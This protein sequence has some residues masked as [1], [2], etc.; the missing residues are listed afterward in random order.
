MKGN[1]LL[2]KRLMWQ[3]VR[4]FLLLG[5]LLVG[6]SVPLYSQIYSPYYQY[7]PLFQYAIFYNIN[8]EVDPGAAMPIV[9]PVFSNEG[10]WSG[11]NNPIYAS[12]VEAAGQVNTNGADPFL[13]TYTVSGGTPA[14]NFLAP[15]QPVSGV[16]PVL[17]PGFGTNNLEAMLNLPPANVA[18]PQEIAYA[19]SN[20]IYTFNEASLIISN[21]SNGT[22]AT[23]PTGNNFAVYLQD[24]SIN[25]FFHA[26]ITGHWNQLT[27]DFYIVTNSTSTYV[28]NSLLSLS[29]MGFTASAI[30]STSDPWSPAANV[31]ITW[32][33]GT[34]HYGVKYAGWSWLTNTTFYDYREAKTVQAVQIDVGLLRTWITNSS[35]TG[36]SNWNYALAYDRGIG[37]DS[38]Y[39]YNNVPLTS[40]QLP[41]VR[42]VNGLRLPNSTN[43]IN[44]FPAITYGLTVATPQPL[45]VWGNY[46]VQIDGDS[47]TSLLGTTNMAHT[48]PAALVADAITVLSANWKDNYISATALSSRNPS[49]TAITAACIMGNVPSSTNYSNVGGVN[50]YSGGLENFLR[51]LE[52]WSAS[53]PLTY[54]GSIAVLF[55]SQYATNWWQQ[56]AYYYNVPKRIWSFDTN[57]DDP[58]LLPPLTPTIINSNLPPSITAQPTNEVVLVNQ[59]TNMTV[60]ASAVPAPG[61]Q[62][63][64]NGTNIFSATNAVLA[65]TNPQLIN[66]GNYTVQVTNVFGSLISSNATLSVYAS[67]MPGVNGASFSAASGMA[68]NVAGVPGFNYAIEVS[69]DL[70]NWQI[71]F[72]NASPFS[73]QDTNALNLSQQ[74]YRVVYLP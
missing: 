42:M 17:F 47:P 2:F 27:N 62:W 69:T 31:N 41:A 1:E 38:V 49:S 43:F 36:G 34:N 67:A 70:I 53:T 48:Y 57:F 11:G 4:G 64:Y 46:N 5:V 58:A 59:S 66:A 71:V 19:A 9:G 18:A 12:T 40:S 65:L 22:H 20:Q 7:A 68:F 56:S 54:N 24:N 35:I 6:S 60:T 61:Y 15:G 25:P 72:T 10:I 33:S 29:N 8:L 74:F 63:S 45:Y 16:A 3:R 21:W 73:F 39:V 13:P 37:I 26:P 30:P 55:P 51:L 50:G 32:T 14:A 28:V 23:A 44:S 52:N